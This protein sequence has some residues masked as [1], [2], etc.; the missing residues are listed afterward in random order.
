MTYGEKL[1]VAGAVVGL[2]FA[3]A[4]G[5]DVTVPISLNGSGQAFDALSKK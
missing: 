5:H 3:D 2:L 4:G 1:R